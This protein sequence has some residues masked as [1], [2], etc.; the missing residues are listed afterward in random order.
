VIRA[1]L[2]LYGNDQRASF[3]ASIALYPDYPAEEVIENE[4]QNI[5]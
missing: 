3:I 5:N 2:P 1:L 4:E